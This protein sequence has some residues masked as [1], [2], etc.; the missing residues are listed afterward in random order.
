[1]WSCIA[2][3]ESTMRIAVDLDGVVAD[4]HTSF[5]ETAARLFPDL[6]VNRLGATEGASPPSQEANAP[7]AEGEGGTEVRPVALSRRQTDAVWREIAKTTDF[8]ESLDEVEPGAVAALAALADERRWEVLFVTSR[9]A[10]AG[11]TVQRQS[12]RWL[13][14]HG[15]PSPS[16][17]VMHG[18]RGKMAKA[19]SIDVV[20]DDRL[21]NCVD[22]SLESH[23]GALLIWRGGE[24][25]APVAADR[26]GIAVVPSVALGLEAVVQAE[27]E[28]SGDLG[29][30]DRLRRL[31]GLQPKSSLLR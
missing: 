31:F 11:A 15:F 6:D 9:P 14:R 29:V 19:L 16:L 2:P 13:E 8:W 30:A 17:W 3:L 24:E 20:F 12:Q 7:G 4:L 27:R 5:L 28:L 18:S 26:V 10:S 1:M 23:A 21:E 22:V 25:T